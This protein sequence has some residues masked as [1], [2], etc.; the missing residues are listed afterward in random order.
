MPRPEPGPV[1]ER[2]TPIYTSANAA[3][4]AAMMA[5]AT[6]DFFMFMLVS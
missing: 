2:L 5:K 6:S 4:P 1:S 3:V